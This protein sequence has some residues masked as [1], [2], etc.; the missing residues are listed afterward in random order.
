MKTITILI[1]LFLMAA[2]CAPVDDDDS[3]APVA[4]R[5]QVT[6]TLMF[7]ER[8]I[9]RPGTVVEVS[10]LDTSRADAPA[11]ELARQVIENP[12]PP[13]IPFVLEY[14]EG[15][16][17]ERFSYSVRAVVKRGD[18][19]LLTT[20][21]HY[22][23]LTRGAGN[24]VELMLVAPAARPSENSRADA[25]LKNTYWKLISIA[26]EPYEHTSSNAEPRIQFSLG[27]DRLSGFTGCNDFTGSY[28][29]DGD[30]LELGVVAATRKACLEGMNIEQRYLQ[31]LRAVD[32]YRISGNMLVLLEDGSPR[33]GFRAVYLQ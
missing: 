6:G 1:I 13:P 5:A 20:D 17:D 3:A 19:L 21:T 11:T 9:L 14:D 7:R 4:G 28:S 10:L 33:L 15:A 30:R 29:V 8:I 16:I 27:E 25:T 12:D 32:A 18:R 23:V 24:S 22:P 31:A 26:G 2:G